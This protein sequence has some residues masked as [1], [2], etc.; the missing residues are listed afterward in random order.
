MGTNSGWALH[1]L[2]RVRRALAL[3]CCPSGEQ[4]AMAHWGNCVGGQQPCAAL[5]RAMHRG[6]PAMLTTI[7]FIGCVFAAGLTI[8][9]CVEHATGP[10]CAV[11]VRPAIR[12]TAT[13]KCH[14]KTRATTEKW[15]GGKQD[16]TEEKRTFRIPLGCQH[17]NHMSRGDLSSTLG[18]RCAYNRCT[19]RTR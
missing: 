2:T 15:Q 19:T 6:L 13:V 8:E 16:G 10:S 1:L 12:P 3:R 4:V 5:C 17:I 7:P 9:L 11:P 14:G 18:K